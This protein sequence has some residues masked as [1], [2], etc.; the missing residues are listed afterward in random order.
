MKKQMP[1][2]ENIVYYICCLLSLGVWWAIKGLIVKA[3]IES[4]NAKEK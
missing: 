4:H 1:I 3:I 2:I